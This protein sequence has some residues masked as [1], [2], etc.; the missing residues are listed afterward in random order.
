VREKVER[1]VSG[2]LVKYDDG[3]WDL[4]AELRERA[5]KV[6][7]VLPTESLVYGSVARGDVTPTSDVDIILLDPVASYAVEL[8]LDPQFHVAERRLTMA[9]P[10]SVPKASITLGDGTVVSWPLLSPKDREADFYGFG[11]ALDATS[12]GPRDRVP[13]VS[14]RLL[15]VVPVGEGHEETSVLGAEVETAR[16]LGLPM[17]IINERVRVLSR[18]DQVGRTGVFKSMVVDEGVTFEQLL[19]SM[20]DGDPAVRRQVRD[21]RGR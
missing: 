13:G 11:G 21:R 20:A 10:N 4:L 15:L 8:A 5:T 9:S 12:V 17:D 16:V 1:H 18:R 19:D 6:Q 2:R 14:K 7:S 3:R